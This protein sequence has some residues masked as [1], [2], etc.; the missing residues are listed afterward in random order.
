[1]YFKENYF[2]FHIKSLHMARTVE[3]MKP[4]NLHCNANTH[5]SFRCQPKWENLVVWLQNFWNNRWSRY[6]HRKND[7]Q[8]VGDVRAVVHHVFT[9]VREL[10][11]TPGM[12]WE[13]VRGGAVCQASARRS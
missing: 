6:C 10:K 11:G 2:S 7:E 8:E 9:I 5:I 13:R 4:S 3:W 1:M 12:T